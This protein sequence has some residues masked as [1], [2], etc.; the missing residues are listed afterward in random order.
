[1]SSFVGW[2]DSSVQFVL[3]PG[4]LEDLLWL[5]E[6]D[7]GVWHQQTWQRVSEQ[8]YFWF[9]IDV[10]IVLIITSLSILHKEKK[11]KTRKSIR[12]N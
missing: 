11:K 3:Q 8:T 1:M 9:V 4:W 6:D 10:Y 12:K 2:V 7:P 5:Q